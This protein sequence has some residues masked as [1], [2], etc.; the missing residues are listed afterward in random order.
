MKLLLSQKNKLYEAI[1]EEGL[2]TSDFNYIEGK[3]ANSKEDVINIFYSPYKEYVFIIQDYHSKLTG[4]NMYL[5]TTTPGTQRFSESD[6]CSNWW[7]LIMQFK[8]WLRNIHRET[9][10]RDR[11]IEL[12][13]MNSIFSSPSP[14]ESNE[15]FF[16]DEQYRLL[17]MKINELKAALPQLSLTANQL[18]DLEKKL[19][20]LLEKSKTNTKIDWYNLFI[21]YIL[22]F[23]LDH[24]LEGST[25]HELWQLVK[26]VFSGIILL[27]T[28]Q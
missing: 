9:Q 10:Q 6:Y 15:S 14:D 8:I 4:E 27:A 22:T 12:E 19:D 26:M 28:N 3:P 11:W 20:I 5:M 18:L 16:S 24:A 13:E 25:V 2:S 23:A 1:L 7:D 17:E 21:G